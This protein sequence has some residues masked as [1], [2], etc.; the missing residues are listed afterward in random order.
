MLISC[1]EAVELVKGLNLIDFIYTTFSFSYDK[2]LLTESSAHLKNPKRNK[3]LDMY[4]HKICPAAYEKITIFCS[5]KICRLFPSYF[6]VIDK[7]IA[8][9]EYRNF[10]LKPYIINVISI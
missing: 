5:R 1:T 3:F 10:Q 8:F 2:L 9:I 7:N 4:V 6:L